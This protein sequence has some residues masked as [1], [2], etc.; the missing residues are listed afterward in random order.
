MKIINNINHRTKSFHFSVSEL[1]KLVTQPPPLHSNLCYF[2]GYGELPDPL[3]C[4][5]YY[6]CTNSRTIR[7]PCPAGL[8]FKPTGERSGLCDYP[9]NVNC[10]DGN[11]S[12]NRPFHPKNVKP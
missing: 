6:A 8:H 7:M 2:S 12:G 1:R 5:N 4:D 9:S 10:I 3:T 11:R